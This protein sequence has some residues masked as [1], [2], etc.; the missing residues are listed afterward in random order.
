MALN[1]HRA[2]PTSVFRLCAPDVDPN[3]GE[4]RN[5]DVVFKRYLCQLN[6]WLEML[7]LIVAEPVLPNVFWPARVHAIQGPTGL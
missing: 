1:F 6:R 5:H 3:D 2:C 4:P 7:L